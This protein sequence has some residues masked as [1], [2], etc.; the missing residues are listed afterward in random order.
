VNYDIGLQLE[1]DVTGIG[2]YQYSDFWTTDLGGTRHVEMNGSI[3]S[4]VST[5]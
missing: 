3:S 4:L 2:A 1:N 5:E